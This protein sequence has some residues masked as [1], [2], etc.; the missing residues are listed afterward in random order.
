MSIA[1]SLGR[2]I[3]R[4]SPKLLARLLTKPARLMEDFFAGAGGGKHTT[5][6]IVKKTFQRVKT[7]AVKAQPQQGTASYS[8]YNPVTGQTV[9]H[10]AS[11]DYKPKIDAVDAVMEDYQKNVLGGLNS[12]GMLAQGLGYAGGY[13]IPVGGGLLGYHMLKGDGTEQPKDQNGVKNP[14]FNEELAKFRSKFQQD[15]LGGDRM[16]SAPKYRA[17]RERSPWVRT[18][19][20]QIGKDKYVAMKQQLAD[21]KLSAMEM[22]SALTDAIAELGDDE[23]MKEAGTQPYVLPGLATSGKAKRVIVIAPMKGKAGGE[24][25]MQALKYA[26]KEE[27]QDQ[28]EQQ[29]PQ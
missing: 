7:P 6:E 19:I 27:Q 2:G 26:L 21:G 1:T 5:R 25:S 8:S 3:F 4:N 28:Q 22:H 16:F 18:A 20:E 23:I 9:V 14:K 17:L 12:T 13:G 15:Y 10:P 11:H 29:G 24:M